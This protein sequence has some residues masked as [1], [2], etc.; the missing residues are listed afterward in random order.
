[1][2]TRIPL[3]TLNNTRDLGGMP[4]AEGKRIAPNRLI[5]SGALFGASESDIRWLS[6][7][8]GL[9]ID[10]RSDEELLEKPDPIIPG[11]GSVHLPVLRRLAAG[12]SRDEESDRKAVSILETHPD[13]MRRYILE[14]Y[15]GFTGDDYSISRYRA[16]VEILLESEEKAVL[17]HCTGGKDRAGFGSVIIEALLG[18]SMED[19]KADY[20]QTNEYLEPEMRQ[21][22]QAI[23]RVK[24]SVSRELEQTLMYAFLARE[25]YLEASFREAEKRYGS[26]RSYLEEGL[27][28]S[29]RQTAKLRSRYLET[30]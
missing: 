7:H 22:V 4:A 24:G 2:S 12:V 25:E 6:D 16:F 1:M 23:A 5:R 14:S 9:V 10:L 17:W 19:I 18:V 3:E 26:F 11:T 28:I 13:D 8:V 15:R 21:I 30:I 29:D 27:G 20:L